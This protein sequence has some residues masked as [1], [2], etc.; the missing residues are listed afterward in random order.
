MYDFKTQLEIGKLIETEL[1]RYF[2]RWYEIQTVSID[3]EKAI[4]EKL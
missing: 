4:T 1:D 2:S 3:V